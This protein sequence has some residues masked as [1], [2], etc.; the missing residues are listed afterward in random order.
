MTVAGEH[1]RTIGEGTFSSKVNGIAA[2]ADMIA[3][4]TNS[5]VFL[6]DVVTGDLTRAFGEE[7]EAEGQLCG[8][9]GLR[10]TPDGGHILIAEMSNDRLSLFTVTGAFVRCLGVGTLCSP[11]DVDI[12]SSGDFLVAD[13][14]NNMILVLSPDGS[15]LLQTFGG[16]G[17]APGEFQCPTALA[18]YGN[19]LYVL[20]NASARVQVFS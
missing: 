3:V 15:T 20:D 10:F 8:C 7:G 11:Y 13:E 19:Q 5:E 2:A 18:M 1:V 17:Y 6:F 14:H 16:D 4:S 12:A 9:Y